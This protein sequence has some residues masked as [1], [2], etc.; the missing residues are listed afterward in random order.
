MYR[1]PNR[2]PSRR[3]LTA[4]HCSRMAAPTLA[5]EPHG[6]FIQSYTL[7]E[8]CDA[9]VTPQTIPMSTAALVQNI[10][11][12]QKHS[13]SSGDLH[14][15]IN[16]NKYKTHTWRRRL[17]QNIQKKPLPVW[18]ELKETARHPQSYNLH[19]LI[20]KSLKIILL[21]KKIIM[22]FHG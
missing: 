18:T 13:M 5:T 19:A 15:G 21:N 20:H 9:I 7:T 22:I 2:K 11:S 6:S 8:T 14:I 4:G 16:C 10:Q 1:H 3:D 17:H 12:V